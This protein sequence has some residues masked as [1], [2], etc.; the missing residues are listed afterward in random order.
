MQRLQ[1][2]NKEIRVMRM[3]LRDLLEYNEIVVQC[4]DNPDA[5]SLACGYGVYRYLSSMGKKPRLIYGGRNCIRKSNLVMLVKDLGIPIEHVD[6][7]KEP[8]LLVMV[9]CQYMG[10]NAVHFPAGQ[11]AVIDHHRVST[12]LPKLSEVRSNLGACSTLVWQLLKEEG[13]DVE[14]DRKLAT[15]LYYGLY[16]DTGSFTEI[17]HPLDKDL[18]DEAKFDPELMVKYR[19]ANLSLEELEVAGAAL[20]HSDYIDEYRCAIVKSAPCDPNILGLISDLVLEV[21]AVDS[22]IVFNVLQD[23]VKLSV[24]SCV[25]EVKANELAAELC[26]DIGSGGG[27]RGKAGG[28]IPMELLAEVYLDFCRHRGFAPRMEPDVT[29]QKEQPTAS[30]IKAV[31]EWRMREYMSDTE[32]LY[33]DELRLDEGTMEQFFRRPV[34]WGYVR[35]AKLFAAGARIT[36]RTLGGDE[37]ILVEPDTI[38]TIGPRGNV[39]VRR[40]DEFERQYRFYPDWPYQMT[41]AEYIPTIKEKGARRIVFPS[42][43]AHVCVP[44]GLSP[45]LARRL[46]HK[47]KLFDS[48]QGETYRLGRKGDYLVCDSDPQKAVIMEQELFEKTCR[49]ASDA[50]EGAKR[51]VIFDLDGTLM[52]TL[53]D[54]RNAVNAALAFGGMPECTLEQVR[55]YLGNGIRSLMLQ[56]VPEGGGNPAFEEVFAYF[57]KYYEK[58]CLDRS[59]PYGNILCLLKELDAQGVS[60]AIVS[61]K[62]DSAVKELNERFFADYIRVALGEMEGVARK[63]APDMV[64]KALAQLGAKGEH[65]LYVGDSEVDIRTA[66][67]AGL[68]CVSV[69]WGFRDAEFLRENGAQTLIQ[70][71][72]ELLY[73]I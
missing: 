16:T 5:D 54:L 14:G 17:V 11:V 47:V 64:Q 53:E 65:T 8:E 6:E 27:H 18:R 46:E 67:N 43:H 50:A 31:L 70:R 41:A 34:P 38:L 40:E 25:K 59:A 44:K 71:P 12:M 30:G 35:A 2:K 49:K 73:L 56:A 48:A 51:A 32:I 7:L 4:H 58:H 29:G 39:Q 26:R 20:L 52:D 1:V 23:G 62:V 24:R 36:V 13:Y 22:C 61:N 21:D 33:A 15:A 63:P 66:A 55:K 68:P 3:K 37:E 9:D 72:L 69:A 19:N 42:K 57:R 45:I 28:F 10:G 60:M